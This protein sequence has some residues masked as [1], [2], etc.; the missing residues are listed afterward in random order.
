VRAFLRCGVVA[1][2][3]HILLV[4]AICLLVLSKLAVRL[5]APLQST[6]GLI[7]SRQPTGKVSAGCLAYRRMRCEYPETDAERQS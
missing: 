1:V 4:N 5:A 2:A 6:S 7:S 3:N